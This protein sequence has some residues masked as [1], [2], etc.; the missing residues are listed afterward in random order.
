MQKSCVNGWCQTAFDISHE[1]QAMLQQFDVPEP[2]MCVLCRHLQR[3]A[4]KET[5]H[6]HH[7]T[8]DL[9]GKNILSVFAADVPFP[10]YSIDEWWSDQWTPA[11]QDVD[12]SRSFFDQFIAL[13]NKIPKMANFNENCEN[14]D[15]CSSAGM[16]KDC[17]YC[18]RAYRGSNLYYS[19]S[20][21]GYND[22]LCD[23]LRCQRCERC[24][25]CVQCQRCHSSSYLYRSEDCADCHFSSSIHHCQNCLF[26]HNLRNKQYHV[27]NQPVSKEE[28]AAVRA[29]TIDGTFSQLQNNLSEWQRTIDETVWKNL[30]NLHSDNCRGDA[31]VHCHDCY[32]CYDCMNCEGDRYCWDLTP[33]EKNVQCMDLT[34]G[35]IGE[36]LYN[37]TGLGGGNY[38]M[39][40]CLK[41][42][43]CA[44]CTYCADCYSC[45]N[46][47]GCSGLKSKR[48][49]IFN[50][51]YPEQEYAKKV[52]QITEHMRRTHST[53][54]GQGG[55]WGM[56]FPPKLQRFPYNESKCMQYVPLAKE[57]VERRGW[58]WRDPVEQPLHVQRTIPG[59]QLPDA[60]SDIPDDILNWA[61]GCSA[62]GKSFRII[63]QE[64]AF[65]RD[66]HLPIP[67]HHPDVRMAGRRS[68][69]N[70][71][72]LWERS[73]VQCQ[74]TIESSYPPA[75]KAI[76]YC[77]ECYL[78][79]VY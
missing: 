13:Y 79:A 54:S 3:G 68:L 61:I 75:S 40:M 12:P 49:C 41:C 14:C 44:E 25:A 5:V 27:R 20:V 17:Y 18:E 38:F 63:P 55:E 42:R 9:S 48:Y 66:M 19:E 56:F 30:N 43:Q 32:E 23:C 58:R 24:Y 4:F 28:F 45:K 69:V 77:E 59:N 34:G 26:C 33:S 57:E 62:T 10:V 53:G 47:F 21:T 6:F 50:K 64:L 37:C 46:C 15:Y 7:R 52:A 1:D 65:Y 35:G 74:K 60:L 2:E 67:R 73:C 51:Q 22:T 36:L 71:Y 70:P 39:R 76:V 11:E 78:K 29:A 16:A 72:R 31:L 8:S